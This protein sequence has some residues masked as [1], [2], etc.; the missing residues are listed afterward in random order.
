MLNNQLMKRMHLNS[1]VRALGGGERFLAGN[2]RGE[3]L[4][5]GVLE[6]WWN[7]R[8]RK[9]LRGLSSDFKPSNGIRKDL[10]ATDVFTKMQQ[11]LG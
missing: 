7:G 6:F 2:G 4:S 5:L 8:E 10:I 11:S 9:Q 1:R 3:F